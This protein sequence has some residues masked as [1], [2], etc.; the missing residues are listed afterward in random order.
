MIKLD[1]FFDKKFFIHLGNEIPQTETHPSRVKFIFRLSNR[2]KNQTLGP[3][4]TN[5]NEF[6]SNVELCGRL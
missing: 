1:H 6:C 3:H 5:F 2:K 4:F